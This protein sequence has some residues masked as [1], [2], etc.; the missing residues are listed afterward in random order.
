MSQWLIVGWAPGDDPTFQGTQAENT[1]PIWLTGG[2]PAGSATPDQRP[3]TSAST[4]TA[5]A[6][7]NPGPGNRPVLRPQG[8]RDRP[9][10][11]DED[12]QEQGGPARY[13]LR[14]RRRRPDRHADLGVRTDDH[15]TAAASSLNAPNAPDA[16]VL[17]TDAMITAAWG[18][19]PLV[20]SPSKPGL[21]MGYTVRNQRSW[22]ATKSA[23]LLVDLNGNGLYDEGDTVRYTITVYNTGAIDIPS[24]GGHRHVPSQ[25]DLRGQFHLSDRRRHTA[26]RQRFDPRMTRRPPSRWT[27]SWLYLHQPEPVRVLQ[28]QLRRDDQSDRSVR[29]HAHQR[30]ACHRRQPDRS[31]PK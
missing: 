25:H 26:T 24:C 19:D 28:H 20:C 10:D 15:D 14:H 27:A 1:A 6:R 12:L 16:T 2:H 30:R 3:T 9:A 31:T 13:R 11:A 22:R 18:S 5:T 4:I 17:N 29:R 21:D 8:H 7:R 23:A